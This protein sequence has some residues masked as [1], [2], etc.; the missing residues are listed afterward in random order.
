M[1][2]HC[3]QNAEA[4]SVVGD[5]R[6]SVEDRDVQVSLRLGSWPYNRRRCQ[7][8]RAVR[9]FRVKEAARPE[10][11][12]RRQSNSGGTDEKAKKWFK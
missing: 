10:V 6:A 8:H 2:P 1:R 3:P 7:M 4:E 9:Q 12:E 5:Y 11:D